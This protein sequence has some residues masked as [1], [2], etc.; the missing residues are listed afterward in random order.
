[1]PNA[2]RKQDF[3]NGTSH[4]IDQN[5]AK[6]E[7]IGISEMARLFDTTY[8]TLRFYESKGLLK[9]HRD[10][11]NRLYDEESK[12]QF[13]L[14]LEGRQLGFTLSEIAKLLSTSMSKDE[15][16]MSLDTMAEQISH[17]EEQRKQIDEALATLRKRYYLMNEP[18]EN[19]QD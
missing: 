14:I 11:V 18:A 8:R 3:T 4:I 9:A 19:D 6:D 13:R 12:R 15:L 7:L 16:Q 2:L 17:L 1:M 5:L 10:G